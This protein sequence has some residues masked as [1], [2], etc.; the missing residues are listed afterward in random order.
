MKEN[1]FEIIQIKQKYESSKNEKKIE[2]NLIEQIHK[3]KIAIDIF[4][5]FAVFPEHIHC[6]LSLIQ[7]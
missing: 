4:A 6:D 5:D 1:G 2:L 7:Y 3:I